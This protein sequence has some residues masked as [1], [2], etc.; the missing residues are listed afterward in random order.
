MKCILIIVFFLTAGSLLSQGLQH[1]ARMNSVYVE[2]YF[3]G[4]NEYGGHVSLNYDRKIGK[5]Q[6]TLVRTGIAPSFHSA[7]FHI[8]TTIGWITGPHKKH[9]FEGAIGMSN[10][11]EFYQGE[12]NYTPFQQIDLMYRYESSKGFLLRTGANFIT[13]I[14]FPIQLNLGFSLGYRF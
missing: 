11:I 10:R 8:P 5:K 9:H 1:S 12:V 4:S 6:F 14:I 3:I 2:G 7:V 13:F